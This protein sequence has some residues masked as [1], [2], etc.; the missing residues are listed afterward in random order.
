MK[1][2]KLLEGVKIEDIINNRDIEV[3]NIEHDSRKVKEDTLFICIIGEKEDGHD[4]IEQA[5][6]NGATALV[7]NSE[8]EIEIDNEDIVVIRV[9]DNQKAMA[10][11][12]CNFFDNPSRKFKLI[13]VTG[14][15]GKT[16]TTYMIKS[17]LEKAGKKVGLVGTIN[18]MI[19]NKKYP[20]KNTTPGAIELQALFYKMVQEN[21]DVVVMEVSSHALA[22]DRV[23]G[24]DFDIGIFTNLSQD[25]MDF[26]KNFDNYVAAKGILFTMCKQGFVNCDDIYSLRI[27]KM[28]TCHISTFGLDNG[29]K[30]FAK[31]LIVTNSYVEFKLMVNNRP[32]KIRVGIPGRFTVYN[33]LAAISAVS[34]LNV[35]FENI[36][37]GLEEVKVPGRS[38]MVPNL[39]NKTIMIDYAH[40]PDSLENILKAVKSYTKGR[41]ICVFGC[42]GDRDKAKRPMMGEVA[43]K[44]ADFTV[45]TS[46]NPRTE[47]PK[48]IVDQIEEGIKN[49]KGLY[50]VIVNRTR[51]IEYALRMAGKYDIVVLAG[52]GHETYQILGEKKVHYDEREIVAQILKKLPIPEDEF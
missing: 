37:Q 7:V 21:V 43:G 42:G 18:N 45:I 1:L 19:G 16:T 8:Y 48:Q 41:V 36:R 30:I 15:K 14:T 10:Q 6:E 51:A 11:I 46:D 5:L 2:S 38:E 4:Y 22:L 49:T 32:E 28:A 17:I 50:K 9:K 25:H 40:S 23:Y 26:H 33:A 20:T 44:I 27:E 3:S 24:C 29:P 52:K 47:D 12:A 13:G 35:D 34:T 39:H 31:D